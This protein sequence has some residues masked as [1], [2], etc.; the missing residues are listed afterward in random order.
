METIVAYACGIHVERFSHCGIPVSRVW[1]TLSNRFKR[2]ARIE[3][4]LQN[5]EKCGIQI[6]E[7][8]K[9]YE[10]LTRYCKFYHR[11]SLIF[12]SRANRNWRHTQRQTI[13][14]AKLR[15]LLGLGNVTNRIARANLRNSG[16]TQFW[17]L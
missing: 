3:K 17:F 16:T 8:I 4:E 9:P 10:Y 13:A 14:R 2:S 15:R 6:R 1:D 12:T 7:N 5:C 11:F